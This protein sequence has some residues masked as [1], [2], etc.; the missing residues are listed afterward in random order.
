MLLH[1]LGAPS[2]GHW[3]FMAPYLS[4]QGYCVFYKTYG[5]VSPFIPFG[6]FKPIAESAE[7]LGDFIDDVRSSTRAAEVDVVG[8]S[9]GGFL[10]L[11]I[12]KMLGYGNKIGTVVSMAPPTHGTSFAGLVGFADGLGIRPQVDVILQ[13]FG[14]DACSDLITNG[15]AVQALTNGPI[16]VAGVDYTILATRTDILVTP[17]ETS[18]VDE[19]GVDNQYVQDTCPLDPVG[20]VGMAFD[21]GVATIISNALDPAH[22]RP[23]ACTIGLPF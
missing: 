23:V 6:G 14:C 12:P 2:A 16:A 17:T 19:P 3:S 15:P 5:E 8:H 21:T 22:A 11:Y 13:L 1:G 9:E 7:E 20:H 4:G 10:S 18:F